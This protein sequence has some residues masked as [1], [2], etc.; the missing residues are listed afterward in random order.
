[1]SGSVPGC[2]LEEGMG[3][4]M[5]FVDNHSQACGQPL[6]MRYLLGKQMT[7]GQNWRRWVAERRVAGWMPY[8]PLLPKSHQ[9]ALTGPKSY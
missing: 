4:G 9:G 1:M 8:H 2:H 7:R 5:D 3:Y 6:Y